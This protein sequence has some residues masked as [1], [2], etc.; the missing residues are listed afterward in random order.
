MKGH[1]PNLDFS[2]NRSAILKTVLLGASSAMA[3]MVSAP[4]LAQT[5]AAPAASAEEIIVTGYRASLQQNLD[6]KRES[7]GVVEAIS[8]E[9]IGKFPD[10]NVAAALQRLPGIS[11]QRS[12]QRGE[13]S[14]VSIRGFGGDFIDTLIDGRHISTATGNRAVDFTTIGSDFVGRLNVYKTPNV[15]LSTSAIGGTINVEMPKPFDRPGFHAVGTASGSFQSRSKDITPSAGLLLSNTFADDTIGVLGSVAYTRTDTT[16]NRVFIPGW[17]GAN[18]APCQAGPAVPSCT[19]TGQAD[20]PEWADPN[21]RNSILTWFPQQTG[22]DQV[23]TKDERVDARIALQW[24]PTDNLLITIDDNYSRQT[25]NSNAFGYAAW[26]NGTSLRNVEYDDNGT[27]VDFSQPGTPMDFN[28]NY[29]RTILETN[30]IGANVKWDLNDNLQ[31]DVDGF[32]SRSTRNPGRNGFNDSMDIGYG[33]I[34]GANTGVAILGPSKDFLPQIHDVGPNGDISRF[35]DTSVIGSHVIVRGAPYNTD[36]VKQLR[37]VLRWNQDDLRL[38]FGGQYMEDRLYG[39]NESTFTNGVFASRSGYG[40]LS[41]NAGGPN[42]G[43]SPLPASVYKGL[44]GTGNW[45][46]GYQGTLAPAAIVYDPYEVY[47]LLEASGGSVAPSLDPGSV[48][49]IREKTYAIFFRA[50]FETDLGGMPFNITAGL[51]HEGTHL[52]STAIGRQLLGLSIPAGDPTLIQPDP[53]LG[54]LGDGYSEATDIARSSNYTYLLPSLDARLEVMPDLLLRMSASRTLTRPALTAL[55][56]TVTLG[57]LR[58]GSLSANGGNPDLKPYLSDNF[59]AAV[60]WYYQ[61]NSYFSAN[62]YL[63]HITNFVVGGVSTQ[64]INDVIDPSTGRIARFNVNSQINGPEATIKGVEVALQHVFGDSGF[65]FQAN[66]TFPWS[67]RNYDPSST[68]GSAFSITGLAKSANFIAFY[69]KDGFQIR[70]AV[71]WRDEYLLQLGQA[72]GGTFGAEPVYVDQ[73]LTIDASASYDVTPWAT[74]FVE[75]NNLNNSTYSTH[76]RFSNQVLDIWSYGR[77]FT[78]GFRLKY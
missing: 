46:P 44:I 37:A 68:D 75:G 62:F 48:Y 29:T 53:S 57:T 3:V 16:S 6:I 71:N 19:P 34:L 9:D 23:H 28:A 73:Q 40:T 63:K 58:V 4:A 39:E 47:R 77:R 17:I 7:A 54:P 33:G 51:R 13:A 66:A 15:E 24:Q 18:F 38:S 76:G 56:P 27:V 41:G 55:R 74:V 65:G 35:T 49:E 64:T 26:F 21:N 69:D 2:L 67:N 30:T 36:T 25:V 50:D 14:G 70:G 72:Q 10:P 60:E 22:I 42:G 78:A 43:I 45:I 59:D 32:I 5:T 11:V 31:L 12:G 52:T 1:Q 20:S 61:R 8:A